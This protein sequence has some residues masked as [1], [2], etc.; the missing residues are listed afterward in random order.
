MCFEVWISFAGVAPFTHRMPVKKFTDR[1]AAVARLWLRSSDCPRMA[2][3][4]EKGC[5]R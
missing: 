2:R 3:P 5:E 1:K 4:G